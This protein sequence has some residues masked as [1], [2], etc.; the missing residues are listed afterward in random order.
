MQLVQKWVTVNRAPDS[1]ATESKGRAK[2]SFHFLMQRN[3]CTSVVRL[4]RQIYRVTI[5][6]TIGPR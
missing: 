1:P 2:L 5:N 3:W 6:L 4:V